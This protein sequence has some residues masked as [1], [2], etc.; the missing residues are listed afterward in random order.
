V[1]LTFVLIGLAVSSAGLNLWQWIAACRFPLHKREPTDPGKQPGVTL[2]K[3]LKG[4]DSE[5]LS[6]IES[7]FRQD[8]PAPVQILCG[9]ASADDL[10]CDVVRS[11]IAKHPGA[12]AQL[13]ICSGDLGANAKVSTLIQLEALASHSILIASDA[14]VSVPMDFLSQVAVRFCGP[15]IGLV[16]CFYRLENV[17]NTAMQWEAVAIN[18]DFWSQVLQGNSIKSMDFALGAVMAVRRESLQRIGG[19]ASL[20]DYLADDYQLGN[21]IAKMG[22]AIC[23]MPVVASCQSEAMGWHEVW[24][25]QLRWVRTIRVCQ[26]T[27]WFCSILSNATFWPLLVAIVWKSRLSFVLL[28]VALLLR[29]GTAQHNQFRLTQSTRHV[30]YFWIVPL[31]D[32]LHLALWVASFLGSVVVWRGVTYRVLRGGKLLIV[33]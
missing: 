25:H 7:W 17:R 11:L 21:K 33:K 18:A 8:Y 19:F 5:T 26:P 10:V 16:N 4:C 1:A 29:I 30:M 32:L 12:N 14:D 2:L 23:M 27:P 24:N 13:V 6:C 31:K 15:E 28:A 3:P 20:A 22:G 9:V